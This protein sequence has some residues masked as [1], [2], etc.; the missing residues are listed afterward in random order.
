MELSTNTIIC[1]N[2]EW[3]EDIL[4]IGNSYTVKAVDEYNDIALN[5]V[6]GNYYFS[7]NRFVPRRV[8]ANITDRGGLSSCTLKII[9][10]SNIAT[11]VECQSCKCTFNGTFSNIHGVPQSNPKYCIHCGRRVNNIEM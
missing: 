6:A 9:H 8:W 11:I 10:R 3:V 4:E 7:T 2:N 5:E 1:I